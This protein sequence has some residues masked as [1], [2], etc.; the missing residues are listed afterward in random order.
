MRRKTRILNIIALGDIGGA[1]KFVASLCRNHD[2]SRFEVMVCVLLS[3]GIV[4]EEIANN[5]SKVAILNMANGFDI[6]RVL[7]LLFI[8]RKWGIDIVNLHCETPL[9]KICSIISS[10]PVI[11]HTDHG[12][13]IGSPV[14]RK[15]RVILFNRL[16]SHFITH[17]IAI[18]NGMKES[19]RK[20]ERVPDNKITLIYNGVD[21]ESIS[22]IS[23]DKKR[24]KESLKIPLNI[25]VLG[26][27][28]RLVEEK[29]Y[30]IFLESLYILKR[31]S[32]NF[33]SIIIGDGPQRENLEEI[34]KKMKLND[35]VLFLGQRND[36]PALLEIID[37][38]GFSSGGEAFPITLLEVMAKAKPI[39]A[40]DVEGVNEA[41]VSGQTGFLVPFG[42]VKEFANKM[43]LLVKTPELA[44]QMGKLAFERVNTL[45]DLKKNI[46][47]IEL[48]YESLTT[49]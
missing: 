20:R 31:E 2:K 37:V 29:Q 22:Q 40:F 48:L 39:V 24:L 6:L 43:L 44:L 38:F 30:P 33:I 1:E 16:L 3:A 21:I 12:N 9:A 7:R 46:Q 8:I 19:L 45:F 42:D 18:S 10:A 23:Y 34:V 41:V 28:G 4:S 47:K 32:V 25:P 35:N 13:T 49:H 17:F 11:I 26:M 27:V 5:G 36:V 14:K 15:K